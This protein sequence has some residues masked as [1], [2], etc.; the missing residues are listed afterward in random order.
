MK[1]EVPKSCYQCSHAR[2]TCPDG[3][4]LFLIDTYSRSLICNDTMKSVYHYHEK[5]HPDCPLD[6]EA[7]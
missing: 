3:Y 6:K 4:S 2:A 5:R 1:K 7:T